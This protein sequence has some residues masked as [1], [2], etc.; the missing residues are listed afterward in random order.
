MCMCVIKRSLQTSSE[1]FTFTVVSL[2]G[3][4]SEVW[5][6]ITGDNWTYSECVKYLDIPWSNACCNGN[7]CNQYICSDQ[8]LYL[9][10]SGRHLTL[11][12]NSGAAF[13]IILCFAF[14]TSDHFCVL[15]SV[16]VEYCAY[17]IQTSLI[18]KVFRH[19]ETTLKFTFTKKWKAD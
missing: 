1:V 8:V 5:C 7:V 15:K 16:H 2:I 12:T 4:C 10:E 13:P 17:Y 18:I 11:T 6:C 9:S 3:F 14:M 19:P